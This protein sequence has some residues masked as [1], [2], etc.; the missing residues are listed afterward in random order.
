MNLHKEAD[1]WTEGCHIQIFVL[2]EESQIWIFIWRRCHIQISVKRVPHSDFCKEGCHIQ[3]S[4]KRG[5]TFRFLY[6]SVPH[7]DFH[8]ERVP[9]P[10]FC[11]EGCHIQISVP[12][13]T[14]FTHLRGVFAGGGPPYRALLPANFLLPAI[15]I[16][17]HDADIALGSLRRNHLDCVPCCVQILLLHLLHPLHHQVRGRRQGG[18]GQVG[19]KI[20]QSKITTVS[21]FHTH[22]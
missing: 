1:F 18:S 12:R 7:L 13:D 17:Y 20:L 6:R 22:L 5:A 15:L 2:K 19:R 9:L 16:F 4:L 10:D 21:C 14:T 3:I 8:M 11:T